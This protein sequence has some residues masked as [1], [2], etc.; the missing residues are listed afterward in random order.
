M[1]EKNLW[2]LLQ[3][4]ESF[5]TKVRGILGYVNEIHLNIKGYV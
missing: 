4:R 1:A 2:Q 3:E 5:I